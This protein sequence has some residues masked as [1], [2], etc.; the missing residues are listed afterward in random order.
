MLQDTRF[1]DEKSELFYK[2]TLNLKYNNI[3][4]IVKDVDKILLVEVHNAHHGNIL[5]Q[6]EIIVQSCLTL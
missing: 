2:N 1:S 6:E 4:K 5:K 3:D